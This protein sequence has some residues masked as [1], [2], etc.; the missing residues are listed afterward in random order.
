MAEW[1]HGAVLRHF[2]SRLGRASV[3][4]ELYIFMPSAPIRFR[5]SSDATII[6]L[7]NASHVSYWG[8]FM[9]AHYYARKRRQR[10]SNRDCRRRNALRRCRDFALYFNC[11][12]TLVPLRKWSVMFCRLWL[13]VVLR[14]CGLRR[15]R[16][17]PY[18]HVRS[19]RASFGPKQATQT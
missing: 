1:F 11:R 8:C 16:V 9:L 4:S 14:S 15:S 5:R 17:R 19:R 7:L 12:S 10:C 2:V 3:H 18:S 13:A 6:I